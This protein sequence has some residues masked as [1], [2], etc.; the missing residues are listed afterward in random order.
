MT[1]PPR[2][3]CPPA[4]FPCVHKKARCHLYAYLALACVSAML[5]VVYLVAVSREGFRLPQNATGMTALWANIFATTGWVLWVLTL[6]RPTLATTHPR[7]YLGIHLFQGLLLAMLFIALVALACLGDAH[8][9]VW[10]GIAL[11]SLGL[12]WGV[13]ARR[14]QQ[15]Q[16]ASAIMSLRIKVQSPPSSPTNAAGHT[17]TPAS[18]SSSSSSSSCRARCETCSLWTCLGFITLCLLGYG[19]GA[20]LTARE[21]VLYPAPGK[22]YILAASPSSSSSSTLTT[23]KMHLYC[24]GTRAD[25]TR[26]VLVFEHGGGSSSF[27]FY[28]VQQEL[29][30]AGIRSCAYDRPGFG[31]GQVLPVGAESLETYNHLLT[32]LLQAANEAPPYVMVGHSV[33]VELVQVGRPPTHPCIV[34]C[35]FNPLTHPPTHPPR[36]LL[37]R[38]QAPWWAC[39]CWMATQTTSVS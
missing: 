20:A 24:T 26:P 27:S 19:I 34:L 6:T 21:A 3:S 23:V 33:G 29:A 39:P 30:A 25:P 12:G 4:F 28:G 36:S 9:A 1:M 8:G 22:H 18:S 35:S 10:S 15:L 7:Y 31:W 13:E 5:A 2:P 17:T 32:S 14:R 38:T 37:L 16:R 11:V